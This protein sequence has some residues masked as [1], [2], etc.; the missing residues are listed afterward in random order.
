MLLQKWLEQ[1]EHL[2]AEFQAAT[3]NLNGSP[4]S[5]L[6]GSACCIIKEAEAHVAHADRQRDQAEAHFELSSQCTTVI[7]VNSYG[8]L[9][10]GQIYFRSSELIT[11]PES[12]T[13]MDI[14]TSSVL[15]NIVSS[16][17][18]TDPE[19]GTQMSIV[20]GSV[21]VWLKLDLEWPDD[22][23]EVVEPPLDSDGEEEDHN[24]EVE[25]GWEYPADPVLQDI[26]MD[27]FEESDVLSQ[28]HA[29]EQQE[30]E[31]VLG[32][33]PTIKKFPWPHA[34]APIL[35][36]GTTTFE[37]YRNALQGADNVWALFVSHIDYE[38]AKWAKLCGSG[39]TAFSELLA[40]KGL[41]FHFLGS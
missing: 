2:L 1:A 26:N 34:G 14:V 37:S 22:N 12:G 3:V 10:E 39:S 21:L 11:N 5:S 16:E 33:Q 32:C 18:I 19:S 7:L 25:N 17:L 40:V 24:A 23:N 13:Q 8:V 27:E 38:V 30:A 15:M 35:N 9:E 31:K 29:A 20:T 28:S 6:S 41:S 4:L 36:S